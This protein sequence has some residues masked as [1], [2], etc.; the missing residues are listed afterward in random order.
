MN[1]VSKR[2]QWA[3]LLVV[4]FAF[5]L[6][7]ADDYCEHYV[8]CQQRLEVEERL[9]VKLEEKLDRGDTQC[10]RS[11]NMAHAAVDGLQLRKTELERDCFMKTGDNQSWSLKKLQ[12]ASCKRAVVQRLPN[13]FIRKSGKFPTKIGQHNNIKEC[14]KSARLLRKQCH[15]LARCCSLHSCSGLVTIQ[16][17]ITSATTFLHHLKWKCFEQK[18]LYKV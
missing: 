5:N 1:G 2:P 18:N 14:R 17:Q 10:L 11:L 13:L 8:S 9:C 6:C 15:T 4:S 12:R 3:I 16:S 7:G